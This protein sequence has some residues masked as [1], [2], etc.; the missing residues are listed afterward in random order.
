M[1]LKKVLVAE[2]EPDIQKIVMM[3]LRLKGYEIKMTNDGEEL[4]SQVEPY[5]PDLILLDV[6]MPKLDGFDTCR[7]LKAN[8]A[9][10]SI[11]VIFLSAS[12]QKFQMDAGLELGAVG[13]LLKPFDPMT[14]ADKLEQI[15]QGLPQFKI[16]SSSS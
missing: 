3:S 6:A 12:T 1:S 14:L 16:D 15:L 5:Q 13:Y 2:D 8:P 9:T 4:L 10:A 11:P 7:R